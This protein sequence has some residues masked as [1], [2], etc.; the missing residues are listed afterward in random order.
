MVQK[1]GLLASKTFWGIIIALGG[2]LLQRFG[3]TLPTPPP[4]NADF[5]T[6]KAFTDQVAAA[7]GSALNIVSVIISGAGSLFAI[8]GRVK[9]EA[10]I[11]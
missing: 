1:K 6:V 3:V 10:T 11:K 9:A 7:K 8:Y 2:F 4:D 5:E